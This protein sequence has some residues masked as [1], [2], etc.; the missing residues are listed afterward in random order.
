MFVKIKCVLIPSIRKR[1]KYAII[2]EIAA[3]V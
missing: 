3:P 1:T 2:V